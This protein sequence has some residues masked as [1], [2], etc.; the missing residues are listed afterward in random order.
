ML[1]CRSEHSGRC[2]VNTMPVLLAVDANDHR[3]RPVAETAPT[4]AV[5]RQTLHSASKSRLNVTCQH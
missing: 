5:S 4:A 3:A 2:T 1:V